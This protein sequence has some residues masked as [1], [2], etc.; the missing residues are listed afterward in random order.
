MSAKSNPGDGQHGRGVKGQ[1]S[2]ADYRGTLR[3]ARDLMLGLM[4]L[5]RR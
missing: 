1:L 3:F 2:D 5:G 4:R